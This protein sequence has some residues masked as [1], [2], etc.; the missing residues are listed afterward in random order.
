MVLITDDYKS[1]CERKSDF[2]NDFTSHG[3]MPFVTNMI[4]GRGDVIDEY[5]LGVKLDDY[6]TKHPVAIPHLGQLLNKL[7]ATEVRQDEIPKSN[8]YIYFKGDRGKSDNL[9]IGTDNGISLSKVD[10]PE[11]RK[12]FFSR[13][14][15]SPYDLAKTSTDDITRGA[16]KENKNIYSKNPRDE[17]KVNFMVRRGCKFLMYDII[18]RGGFIHYA[19]DGLDM[20]VV[21]SKA[22]IYIGSRDKVPVCTS[23]IKELFRSWHYFKDKVFFYEKFKKVQPPWTKDPILWGG[24]LNKR[25]DRM[26]IKNPEEKD[27]INGIKSETN[28]NEKIEKYHRSIWKTLPGI[29][30][31]PETHA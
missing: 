5:W 1:I 22:S 28:F 17:Y 27:F 31:E 15:N 30:S 16:M 26:L 24:Y 8:R 18:N 6:C 14:Q 2:I 7:S 3:S 20:S 12:D 19:L 13:F 23:E 10:I 21:V 4:F 25:L 29:V 11:M 9:I